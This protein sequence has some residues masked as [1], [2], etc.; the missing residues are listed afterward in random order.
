MVLRPTERCECSIAAECLPSYISMSVY[1]THLNTLNTTYLQ[2]PPPPSSL[3]PSLPPFLPP[4]LP[5]FL[6][7]HLL[8]GLYIYFTM[9][10]CRC[11]SGRWR[12]GV[13]IYLFV[14]LFVCLFVTM[15][16]RLHFHLSVVQNKGGN[17][18]ALPPDYV[19][20]N[21]ISFTHICV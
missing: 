16:V 3:Q 15:C 4:F 13:Y 2:I 9:Y 5:S 1:K 6:P 20:G 17:V 7:T 8:A 11:A 18:I 12:G 10:V 19:G 21:G 14:C